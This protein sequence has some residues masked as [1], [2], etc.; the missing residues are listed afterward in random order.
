LKLPRGL[1][2]LSHLCSSKRQKQKETRIDER[3]VGYGRYLGPQVFSEP[4]AR[5]AEKQFQAVKRSSLK[6]KLSNSNREQAFTATVTPFLKLQG[7]EMFTTK[8]PEHRVCIELLGRL[9][10]KNSQDKDIFRR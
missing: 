7:P 8:Q 4:T 9:A 10:W 1:L 2:V 3:L 5:I 6:V